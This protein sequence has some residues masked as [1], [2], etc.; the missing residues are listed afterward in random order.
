VLSIY[1]FHYNDDILS[2]NHHYN[3]DYLN[4]SGFEAYNLGK[5]NKKGDFLFCPSILEKYI[6]PAGGLLKSTPNTFVKI[7]LRKETKKP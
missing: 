5:L 7:M 4:E 1:I 6:F 3:D 2:Y